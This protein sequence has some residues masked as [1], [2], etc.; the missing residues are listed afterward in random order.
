MKNLKS[1]LAIFS[2]CMLVFTA[3]D[4]DNTDPIVIPPLDQT[5]I[6][7]GTKVTFTKV[8]AAD[9]TQANSQDR[10][11]SKVWITRANSGGQIYNA[12]TETMADKNNSPE[13]TL[14]AE[15]TT[16]NLQNLT[17][18]K[19]RAAVVKP[20]DVVGKDLVLLLVE[21][22]IAID[23]KFTEWTSSSTGGFAYERSTN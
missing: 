10:I 17:F 9:P 22:N 14:W 15:G 16:A 3:C 5:T 1:Y 19:F 18:N 8:A 23:V 21:E 20:Q 2:I 7:S 4:Q 12:V 6:W 13:G 11:T